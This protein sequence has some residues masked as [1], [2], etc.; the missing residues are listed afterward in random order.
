MTEAS[1]M[2]RP[3]KYKEEYCQE[4]IEFSKDGSSKV[5]FCA[6]IGICYDT[7]LD[8]KKKHS[9]FSESIKV[10]DTVCQAWWESK[11]QKAIFGGVEGFNPT[12]YIFNMKNRF[13]RDY[14]DKQDIDHTSSDGSMSPKGKSLDDFYEDD[15]DVQA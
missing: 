7:F 14:K 10:A 12:G 15:S 3:T 11:G 5:Q 9:D 6:H 4:L 13:S 2:G 1:K 8:W